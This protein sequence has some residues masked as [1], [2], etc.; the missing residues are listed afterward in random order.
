MQKPVVFNMAVA[1]DKPR[2]AQHDPCPFCRR[3]ALTGILAAEG[4]CLWLE[5]KYPVLQDAYMTVVVESRRCD[6][7]I[8][9]YQAT[10]WQQI[11]RFMIRQWRQMM[12]DPEYRSV[13]LYRN[14]GPLSGGSIRHPHSQI[15]G[16]R[17]FDYRENIRP[18]HFDGDVYFHDEGV[19]CTLS[20]Q[21]ICGFREFNI[22]W[23]DDRH[24]DIVAE[25]IR[26]VASFLMFEESGNADSYNLFFYELAGRSYVKIV[27]RY[28]TSPLYVGYG[29][30]QVFSPTKRQELVQALQE[31]R[32][33][34]KKEYKNLGIIL[35]NTI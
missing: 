13:I 6:G 2:T 15:I 12:S 5:N 16:Y 20:D 8:T 7:D 17:E 9:N 3:S 32:K 26:V 11:L 1:K 30:S 28:V 14:F 34:S 19:R 23:Q 35:K 29:L 27:P 31:Y 10:E 4:D 33:K 18:E 25:E 21:P 22:S 24:L